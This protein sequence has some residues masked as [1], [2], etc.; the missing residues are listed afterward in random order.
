MTRDRRRRR[1]TRVEREAAYDPGRSIVHTSISDGEIGKGP[2]LIEPAWDGHRV[3]V[4]KTHDRARI[5]CAGFRDWTQTFPGVAKALGRLAPTRFAI[6]GVA[7]VMDERGA[8]SFERLRGAVASGR[9]VTG[10][11]LI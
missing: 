3:L 4:T 7:C 1:K 10:A 8:P 2:H 9:A 6:D 11:V 5:V